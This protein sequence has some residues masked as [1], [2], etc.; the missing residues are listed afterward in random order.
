ML[1]LFCFLFSIFFWYNW[2]ELKYIYL[3]DEIWSVLNQEIIATINI[4]ISITH[5]DFLMPFCN[6]V[7]FLLFHI[8][9][10]GKNKNKR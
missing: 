5:E 1:F 3:K 9:P 8:R 7:Y 6:Y 4:N 10:G 2:S